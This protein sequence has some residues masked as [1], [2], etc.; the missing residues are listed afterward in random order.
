MQ[1]HQSGKQLQ[2]LLCIWQLLIYKQTS[3]VGGLCVGL[4]GGS[5]HL[6]L[7]RWELTI[8]LAQNQSKPWKSP[9]G[10]V[11]TLQG[12]VERARFPAS[13]HWWSRFILI[14]SDREKHAVKDRTWATS[15]KRSHE[16]LNFLKISKFL[17]K[18]KNKVIFRYTSICAPYGKKFFY[19]IV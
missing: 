6:N 1:T 13:T 5:A 14:C 18:P 12:G 4:L 9:Y 7:T 15:L 16:S 3:P 2:K 10:V 11:P 17:Q 8:T 19:L